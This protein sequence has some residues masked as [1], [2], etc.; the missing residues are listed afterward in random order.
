MK[1]QDYSATIV[2]N[3]TAQEAFDNINRV[4]KW[5]TENL[6]GSTQK[7]NDEFA[8]RFGSVHYSRQKLVEVIPDKKVVWL[9]TDS[10]LNFVTDKQEWTGTKICFEIAEKDGK[11][12]IRFTHKG[13]VPDYECF[14]ACSN[15]WGEYIQ[16]SLLK[17]INIGK[18]DPTPKAD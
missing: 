18:G 13:L 5:W 1:K 6:E 3:A 9:V 8:V 7:L 4:T 12:Q 16:Q 15:A 10:Q 2:V 14:S 11:T 17:L